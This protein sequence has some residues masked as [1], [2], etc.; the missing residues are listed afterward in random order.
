MPLP[1]GAS[2]LMG[3]AGS[4]HLWLICHVLDLPAGGSTVRNC[5]CWYRRRGRIKWTCVNKALLRPRNRKYVVNGLVHVESLKAIVRFF[6]RRLVLH[7]GRHWELLGPLGRRGRLGCAQKA[8]STST[9]CRCQ[10]YEF[11]AAEL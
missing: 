7:A 11:S 6:V 1:S 5:I 4:V 3:A 8:S 9:S 2:G 10:L